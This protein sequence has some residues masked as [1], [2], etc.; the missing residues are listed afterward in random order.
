MRRLQD[1]YKEL[2]AAF[3]AGQQQMDE[4][5]VAGAKAANVDLDKWAF[6]A[7]A[8]RFVARPTATPAAR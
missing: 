3:D 6:D 7:D 8:L 1:E 4:A 5:I 2:K